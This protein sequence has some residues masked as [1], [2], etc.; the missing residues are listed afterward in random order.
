[1]KWTGSGLEI[2]VLIGC[3]YRKLQNC[4]ARKRNNKGKCNGPLF[5]VSYEIAKRVKEITRGSV[6][7]R[8]FNN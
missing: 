8:Y 3:I 1:M 4:K 5:I 2:V 6:M 7:G